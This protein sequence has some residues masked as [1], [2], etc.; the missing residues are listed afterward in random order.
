MNASRS[1][2]TR[3]TFHWLDPQEENPDAALEIISHPN[4]DLNA[5]PVRKDVGKV[6]VNSPENI[7]EIQPRT[8]SA[9]AEHD[10]RP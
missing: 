5:I 9:S 6:G 1:S 4:P 2:L 3:R 8:L 10:L 7:V